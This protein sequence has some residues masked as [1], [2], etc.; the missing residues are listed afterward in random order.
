MRATEARDGLSSL[1]C[2]P[3]APCA[4]IYT[5]K[6]P[7]AY[8]QATE[9]KEQDKKNVVDRFANIFDM[10]KRNDEDASNPVVRHFNLPNYSGKTS[11]TMVVCSLSLH[12]GWRP[13][14]SW[15]HGCPVCPIFHTCLEIL[16]QTASLSREILLT[17]PF[18]PLKRSIS[19][20]DHT[21]GNVASHAG[22]FRG[23]RISSVG[24]E[25]IR[26]PQK[27]PAW[28]AICN[29]D[30]LLFVVVVVGKNGMSVK[31]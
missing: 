30:K 3:R 4:A 1:A 11:E 17:K 26:A 24:R 18:T 14:P 12:Q 7:S 20:G 22:V 28:E 25:E 15:T 16:A 29:A 19:A 6:I 8:Y 5:S 13:R 2:L 23:A 21:V 27:R 10:L 9:S 31:R